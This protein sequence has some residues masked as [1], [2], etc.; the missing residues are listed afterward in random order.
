MSSLDLVK[1]KCSKCGSSNRRKDGFVNGVQRYRCKDCG[2]AYTTDRRVTEKPDFKK[3]LALHLY[4]E[5]ASYRVIG[6]L[7]G[8]NHVNIKNWVDRFGS[9]LHRIRSEGKIDKVEATKMHQY[10]RKAVIKS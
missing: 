8:E 2:Y 1:M 5:G 10:I 6:E 7:L 4:M 3:R 9:G